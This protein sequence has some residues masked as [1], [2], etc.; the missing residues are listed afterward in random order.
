[1]FYAVG[2]AVWLVAEGSATVVGT[3]STVAPTPLTATVAIAETV[4]VLPDVIER[5]QLRSAFSLQDPYPN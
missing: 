1:M 2:E 4:D 3:T 5:P